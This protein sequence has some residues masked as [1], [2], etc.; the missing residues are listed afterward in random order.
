MR[1]T[2][3]KKEPTFKWE[4][5]KLP[6]RRAIEL[7]VL[8]FF[9]F[10]K[11]Q[12]ISK[13]FYKIEIGHVLDHCLRYWEDHLTRATN[14][15]PILPLTQL[16]HP[17]PVLVKS[18]ARWKKCLETMF[19]SSRLIKSRQQF[20]DLNQEPPSHEWEFAQYEQLH[21]SAD[22]RGTF[23]KLLMEDFG[24]LSWFPQISP[25]RVLFLSTQ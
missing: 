18:F 13:S 14:V 10:Q 20:G 4:D 8:G 9:R 7:S 16:L 5:F 3:T 21:A 23:R 15:P 19:L 24:Q 25:N 2:A 22:P 6:L 12:R 11:S 17:C 1:L